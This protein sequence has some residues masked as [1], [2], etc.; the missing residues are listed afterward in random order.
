MPI[1][2]FKAGEK[3]TGIYHSPT[4]AVAGGCP[5]WEVPPVHPFH[6]ALAQDMHP[7]LGHTPRPSNQCTLLSLAPTHVSTER[8]ARSETCKSVDNTCARRRRRAT[9]WH[10]VTNV[11]HSATCAPGTVVDIHS[12]AATSTATS[13]AL[14]SSFCGWQ[15]HVFDGHNMLQQL[16]Y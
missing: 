15:G 1:I 2:P 8:F 13:S 10:M 11:A 7:M 4:R 5:G 9:R 12:L 3:M 16:W 6:V 14:N